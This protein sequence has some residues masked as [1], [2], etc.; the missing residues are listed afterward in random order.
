MKLKC[1]A[2]GAVASLDMLLS[3]EGAREAILIA[4]QLPE[5]LGK[6]V[7]QYLGLFR[8]AERE[9]SFDRVAKILGELLPDIQQNRIKA[10]GRDWVISRD[11][12]KAGLE[13]VLQARDMGKLKPPLKNHNYLYAVLASMVDR[14]ESKDETRREQER[15]H[16]GSE[17][18][19]SAGLV[20]VGEIAAKQTGPPAPPKARQPMPDH[21]RAALKGDSKQ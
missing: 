13:A 3:H 8:P 19:S 1:P 15:Q 16:G 18:R 6:I 14:V 2:C 21:V 9:L 10:N 11:L 5:S 7:I 4:L 12:W 20:G 17:W